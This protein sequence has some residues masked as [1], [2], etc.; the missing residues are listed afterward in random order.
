MVLR[1]LRAL[2]A[3]VL[4]TS[5]ALMHA[6]S[7]Q[8]WSGPCPWGM[9]AETT[10]CNQRMDHLYD[11]VG[12]SDPWTP[13]ADAAQLGGFSL[14]LVA[15]AYLLLPWALV[16]RPGI[17]V[18]AAVVACGLAIGDIGVATVQSGLAGEVVEPSMG[19]LAFFVW[20]WG[21][22]ATLIRLS[23]LARGWRRASAILL[24]L[25]TPMV[26][27]LTSAVGSFD[28]NPWW[29]AYYGD[30]T[31]LGGLCLLVAAVRRPARECEPIT[32]AVAVA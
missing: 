25:A 2:T 24:A 28:A 13:V 32:E 17:L 10:A 22:T 23:V 8:R 16:G 5:G 15:L 1:L 14:L 31:A 20:A 12:I 6:A 18:T 4:I 30:L 3:L 21:S 29:E 27:F 19:R 7:W 26:A 11:F 9:R